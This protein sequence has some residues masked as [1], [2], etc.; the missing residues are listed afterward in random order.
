M[1]EKKFRN[2]DKL[3]F[4]DRLQAGFRNPADQQEWLQNKADA[5]AAEEEARLREEEAKRKQG[6]KAREDVGY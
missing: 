5:R 2:S 1:A 3:H 4:M 6:T